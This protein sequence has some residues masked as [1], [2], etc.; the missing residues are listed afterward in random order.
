MLARAAAPQGSRFFIWGHTEYIR[1][2]KKFNSSETVA[3]VELEWEIPPIKSYA[4]GDRFAVFVTGSHN[5]KEDGNRLTANIT[6]QCKYRKN[7]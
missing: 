5:Q 1:P 4:C 7:E 6:I 3:P 2:T